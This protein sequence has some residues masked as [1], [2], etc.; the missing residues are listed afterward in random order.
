MI[1][2]FQPSYRLS[3]N[4]F[5]QAKI[6]IRRSGTARLIDSYQAPGSDRPSTQRGVNYT[7][8]AVL[9]C[10][11]SL[12]ILGR[13]PSYKAILNTLADLS[14]RQL[15]EV[16]CCPSLWMRIWASSSLVTSGRWERPR[17]VW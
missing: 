2:D 5:R 14:A 7:I 13:T 16:G 17:S 4:M 15:A 1:A 10:A 9:I 3:D 8:E 6:I 11:L 12:I